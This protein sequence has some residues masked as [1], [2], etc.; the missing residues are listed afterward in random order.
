MYLVNRV[1]LFFLAKSAAHGCNKNKE[2]RFCPPPLTIKIFEKFTKKV[3]ELTG[4]RD[5]KQEAIDFLIRNASLHKE[6]YVNTVCLPNCHL[7]NE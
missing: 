1:N 5:S 3:S 4:F 7:E 6:N 2:A